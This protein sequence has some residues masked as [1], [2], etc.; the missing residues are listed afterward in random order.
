MVA[1]QPLG[2][3]DWP[4]EMGQTFITVLQMTYSVLQFALTI[5]VAPPLP[6][7]MSLPFLPPRLSIHKARVLLPEVMLLYLGFSLS[8]CPRCACVLYVR[9]LLSLFFFY[10]H[11]YIIVMGCVFCFA[12]TLCLLSKIITCPRLSKIHR[13]KIDC[14]VRSP[15]YK[16]G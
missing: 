15:P 7:F 16:S 9:F 10:L 8:S 2:G 13:Y 11:N 1:V 6:A 5:F 4:E 14:L 12:L 3:R